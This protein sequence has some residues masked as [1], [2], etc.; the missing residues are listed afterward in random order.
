MRDLDRV[1][2]ASSSAAGDRPDMIE[3]YMVPDGV[4]PVAQGHVLNVEL[5]ARLGRTCR[6]CGP[7]SMRRA[8][9]SPVAFAAAVM[10][11]RLPA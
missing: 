6:S 10:M 8:I 4:H 9:S 11:S 1:D 7:F 5:V 3:P 2:P